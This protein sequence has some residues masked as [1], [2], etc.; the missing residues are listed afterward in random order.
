MIKQNAVCAISDFSEG[1]RVLA[2]KRRLGSD[3]EGNSRIFR[4]ISLTV[5]RVTFTQGCNL[6]GMGKN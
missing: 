1:D 5:N 6:F 4:K 2:I 3:A